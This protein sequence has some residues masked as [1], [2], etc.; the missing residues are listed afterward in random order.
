[1]YIVLMGLYERDTENVQHPPLDSMIPNDQ[2]NI[3]TLK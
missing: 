1:M 2:E 3:T